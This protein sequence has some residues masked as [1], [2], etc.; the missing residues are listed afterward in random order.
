MRTR[1][2]RKLSKGGPNPCIVVKFL[3]AKLWRTQKR[4]L[5]V[6]ISRTSVTKELCQKCNS[7]LCF[8]DFTVDERLKRD[9]RKKHNHGCLEDSEA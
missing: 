8:K 9:V 2:E 4:L 5:N 6:H 3:K 1:L 7:W